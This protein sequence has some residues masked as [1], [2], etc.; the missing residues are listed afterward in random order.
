MPTETALRSKSPRSALGVTTETTVPTYA[1][2]GR[3]LRRYTLEAIERLE[4]LDLVA[5]QRNRKGRIVAAHFR[6]LDGANPIQNNAHM[7][8]SYSFEQHL[9]SGRTAWKHRKLIQD[10]RML[11]TLF[12]ETPDDRAEAELFIRAIF[13][14]VPLSCMKG[15]ELKKPAKVVSIEAGRKPAPRPLEFDSKLRVA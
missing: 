9:A 5:V 15:N 3:R 8:Q 1:T 6:G 7:G 4:T 2:D 14:A 10:G 12:G 11:E 13:R